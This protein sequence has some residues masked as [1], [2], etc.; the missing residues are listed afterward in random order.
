MAGVVRVKV[1]IYL[2]TASIIRAASYT[3]ES[4]VVMP[5]ITIVLWCGSQ[6]TSTTGVRPSPSEGAVDKGKE[7]TWYSQSYQNV[8]G[9]R[10]VA[11]E[12]Q[13]IKSPTDA[14]VIRLGR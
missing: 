3:E 5:A 9:H 2:A 8:V 7:E 12:Q 4:M 1:R 6:T 10:F 11:V 13:I 14:A